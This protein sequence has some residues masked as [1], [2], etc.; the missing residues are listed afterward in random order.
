[1]LNLTLLGGKFVFLGV[2]YLFVFLVVRSIAR[3]L[4]IPATIAAAGL[5]GRGIAV[6]DAESYAGPGLTPVA[7]GTGVWALVVA[8]SPHL[9][10]GSAFL[11][12][13][14]E[15]VLIGRAAECEIV[16]SDTFVSSSHA[17][18]VAEAEGLVVEDLGST[19]GTVVGGREVMGSVLVAHGET[20]AIGDTVFTVE[21]R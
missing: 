4:R 8:E 14:G 5:S 13:V 19:N 7:Q 18:V 16:L 12:P 17:R 9:E 10:V 6:A 3:D 11:L 20:I 1:M 15:R 2:L 21:S